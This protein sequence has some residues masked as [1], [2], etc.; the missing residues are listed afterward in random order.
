MSTPTAAADTVPPP[1][2]LTT[3]QLLRGLG[4]G[5]YAFAAL[6]SAVGG[7]LMRP[8]LLLYAVTISGLSVG[9]AGLALSAGFV[10]GMAAVP[11]A[12]RWVDR[13]ARRALMVSTLMLRASG[14]AALLLVPGPG[15]FVQGQTGGTHGNNN[16]GQRG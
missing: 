16:G 2:K 14:L 13:G 11:F 8:F 7:G 9:G 12:G 15:G 5:R 1:T 4:G 6:V 10:V 3:I